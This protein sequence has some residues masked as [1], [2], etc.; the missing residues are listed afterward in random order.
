MLVGP[1]SGLVG[2]RGGWHVRA[3][4]AG[5]ALASSGRRGAT[6]CEDEFVRGFLCIVA[7]CGNRAY[8]SREFLLK[9]EDSFARVPARLRLSCMG[10][11]W[12][13]CRARVWEGRAALWAGEL[14]WWA[15]SGKVVF[16][17]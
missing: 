9:Y 4:P 12:A 1:L 16:L 3:M 2:T 13:A 11:V 5:A 17:F 14:R 7:D 6:G 10:R 15:A 8:R